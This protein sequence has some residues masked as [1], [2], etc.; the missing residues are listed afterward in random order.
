ME[1]VPT[2]A[3]AAQLVPAQFSLGRSVGSVHSLTPCCS[4]STTVFLITLNWRNLF[5]THR[6][7]S[8]HCYFIAD[9]ASST[10]LESDL[11]FQNCNLALMVAVSP[12][13]QY[14]Q[15]QSL[16]QYNQSLLSWPSCWS[17][18]PNISVPSAFISVLVLGTPD[19]LGLSIPE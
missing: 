9:T 18:R 8:V 2:N 13:I 15:S 4:K 10:V 11:D 6:P 16:I 5:S 17:G 12:L 14:N 7:H 19:S 3:R 1:V